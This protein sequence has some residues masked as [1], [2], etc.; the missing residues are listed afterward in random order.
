M[1]IAKKFIEITS[2]AAEISILN[3]YPLGGFS[4]AT[5]TIFSFLTFSF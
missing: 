5:T 3:F 2:P 1:M 4:E